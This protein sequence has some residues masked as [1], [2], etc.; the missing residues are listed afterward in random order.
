MTKRKITPRAAAEQKRRAI[1]RGGDRVVKLLDV[2]SDIINSIP[3]A[4]MTALRKRLESEAFPDDVSLRDALSASV[5]SYLPGVVEGLLRLGMRGGKSGNKRAWKVDE[6]CW[7]SLSLASEL[8]GVP[9]AR[10]AACCLTRFAARG[11]TKVDL[12]DCWQQIQQ[13]AATAGAQGD[14]GLPA[15][16]IRDLVTEASKLA[17]VD[18]P[19]LSLYTGSR[20]A[21]AISSDTMIKK[22][23]L[24][25]GRR[26]IV[27]AISNGTMRA[28]SGKE[29][30]DFDL[31]DPQLVSRI[32]EWIRARPT[33][34]KRTPPAD[35]PASEDNS[36]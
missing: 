19:E 22:A 30:A 17:G 33:S 10:L 11:F 12:A 18:A 9:I 24:T 28:T 16:V 25:L 21:V 31:Q 23:D 4:T 15:G 8:T 13:V 29:G 36:R 7:S 27:I 26:L 32:A 2:P 34:K 3:D 20:R 1:K 5:S 6:R 35:R 14:V